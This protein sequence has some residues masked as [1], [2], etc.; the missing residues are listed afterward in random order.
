MRACK[1][2][3]STV[4][5][6]RGKS[7][8]SASERVGVPREEGAGCLPRGP[9]G[10]RGSERTSAP[11]L[12][13]PTHRKSSSRRAARGGVLFSIGAQRRGNN[14]KGDSTKAYTANSV[15]ARSDITDDALASSRVSSPSSRRII[16][17]GPRRDPE[18]G[19]SAS[20]ARFV[21][22]L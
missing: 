1:R 18:I 7:V 13:Y 10:R 19:E 21:T 16:S 17:R 5:G 3:A 15:V 22:H 11:H 9:S 20:G 14:T 4:S 8:R 2:E 6:K 12:W